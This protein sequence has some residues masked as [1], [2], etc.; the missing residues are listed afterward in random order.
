[1]NASRVSSWSGSRTAGPLQGAAEYNCCPHRS[2]DSGKLSV[3]RP[4][5]ALSACHQNNR[6]HA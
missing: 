3:G 6:F 5:K 2:F 1:M 4:E